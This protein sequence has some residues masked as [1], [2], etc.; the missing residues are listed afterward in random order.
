MSDLTRRLFVTGS[1]LALLAP[2]CVADDKKEKGPTGTWKHKEGQTVIEFVDKETLKLMPHGDKENIVIECSY[3]VD[4]GVVKAKV[5]GHEGK[6]EI[7]KKLAAAV[8]LKS[9]FTFKWAVDGDTAGIDE[10]EGKDLDAVK[11][12][13]EGKYE[14]K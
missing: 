6:E 9:E 12:R 8:P 5:T 4:K 14:K 11:S 7:K 2:L 13:I 3:T 10:F 1:V